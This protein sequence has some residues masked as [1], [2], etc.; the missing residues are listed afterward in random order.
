MLPVH[1]LLHQNIIIR[2]ACQKAGPCDD[3]NV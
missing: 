2:M 3:R 1:F